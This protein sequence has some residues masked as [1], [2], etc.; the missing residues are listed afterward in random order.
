MAFSER[1]AM[2]TRQTLA[3]LWLVIIISLFHDPLTPA[4]SQPDS[5]LPLFARDPEACIRVQD[6]CVREVSHAIGSPMY[7]GILLPLLISVLFLFG[8]EFWRRVCPLSYFSQLARNFDMVRR[9]QPWKK[10]G[11]VSASRPAKVR[12]DSFVAKHHLHIQFGL[13]YLALV[14]RILF[15]NSSRLALGLFLLS[16]IVGAILVGFLYDGKS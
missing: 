15:V 16:F 2:R 5:P 11:S 14:A 4:L 12:P 1:V 8:H 9:R 7:W 6:H 13:F 10:S 3:G